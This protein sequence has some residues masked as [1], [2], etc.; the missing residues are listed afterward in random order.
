MASIDDTT[1]TTTTTTTTKCTYCKKSE[2]KPDMVG[3]IGLDYD[4]KKHAFFCE[5]NKPI[6]ALFNCVHYLDYHIYGTKKF[7]SYACNSEFSD[8][9]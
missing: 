2:P 5:H 9:D 8:S 3:C 4:Y 7:I 6:L 1:T